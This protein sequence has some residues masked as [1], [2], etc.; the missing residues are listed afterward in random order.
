MRWEIAGW[1]PSAQGSGHSQ[2]GSHRVPCPCPGAAEPVVLPVAL[3][4]SWGEATQAGLL[5]SRVLLPQEKTQAVVFH[6]PC[7][8]C[9]GLATSGLQRELWH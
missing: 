7:G 2:P 9:A 1:Q 5:P 3:P 4:S 6:V 8:W